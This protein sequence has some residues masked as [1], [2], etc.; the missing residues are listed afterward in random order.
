MERK[1]KLIKSIDTT[2]IEGTGDIILL[3]KPNHLFPQSI[4]E[5][6]EDLVNYI[7]FNIEWGPFVELKN[8]LADEEFVR[9]NLLNLLNS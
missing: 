5:E 2:I 4:E 6:A 1:N 8:V 9:E 7:L 3:I